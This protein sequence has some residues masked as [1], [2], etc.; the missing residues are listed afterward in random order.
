M[1][2]V[3]VIVAVLAVLLASGAYFGSA[4]YAANDLKAAALSGNADRIEAAVDF[5]LVR[6]SLK[7]QLATAMTKA[8]GDDPKLKDN[9]FA[10]LGAML[11][12]AIIDR[13][14]DAFVTP[15]GIAGLIRN[16]KPGA[17][18]TPVAGERNADIETSS[19][20]VNLDR[21]RVRMRNKRTN[22]AGPA[23][24]FERRGLLS[25]KLIRIELPDAM[26]KPGGA[27][28]R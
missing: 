13:A 2:K 6:E 3:W 4:Y 17:D 7:S 18:A 12:P 25:W 23:L 21:F 20:W 1:R 5:A 11:A 26:L 24:L 19:E 15:S 10:G 27:S 28:P 9:P 8:L 22:E 14:I 16:G